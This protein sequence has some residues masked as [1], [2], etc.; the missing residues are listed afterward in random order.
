MKK[1][2][3]QKQE[4]KNKE[5]KKIAAA[6]KKKLA[7]REKALKKQIALQKKKKNKSFLKH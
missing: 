1:I 2:E 7:E 4:L 5:L 6:E 3:N